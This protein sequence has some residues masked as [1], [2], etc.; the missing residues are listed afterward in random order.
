MPMPVASLERMPERVSEQDFEQFEHIIAVSQL[1]HQPMV[2]E[3]F[4]AY[5]DRI[6][7]F[8]IGDLHMESMESAMP[9][10]RESLNIMLRELVA[11]KD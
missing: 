2:E 5:T 11:L 8:E 1:E 6:A 4:S 7:Y 9:R 10:L 3:Q